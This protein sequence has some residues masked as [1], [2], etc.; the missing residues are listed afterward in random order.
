MLLQ[1]LSRECMGLAFHCTWPPFHKVLQVRDRVHC[2]KEGV[3]SCILFVH[4]LIA[5]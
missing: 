5:A 1:F 2:G 4:G 3:T